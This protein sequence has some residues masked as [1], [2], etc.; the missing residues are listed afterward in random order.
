MEYSP[1]VDRIAGEGAAAWDIHAKA[2]ADQAA[3]EDVIVLSV[4]DPDLDTPA[5]VAESA[6]AA[7]RAG[8]THYTPV[9]GRPELRRAIAERFRAQGGWDAGPENVSVVA[10]AQNGLFSAALMLLQPGDEALILDP[11]YVTYDATVRVAGAEPVRVAPRADGGFRPDPEAIAA[12]VTPKTRALL[13]TTPNNPTGVTLTADELDAIAAIARRHDLWVVS[14][15]VYAGLTFGAPHRSIAAL[16]GMAERTITVSSLSKS[17][18]MTGWRVGWMIGPES[19]VGHARNLSLCMHYGLPGFVQ[20]AAVTAL[21][22]ADSVAGEMRGIYRGR[23][24]RLMAGLRDAPGLTPL[25]PE[26]GMFLMVDIRATGLS[27]TDFAWALYRETGVSAL[28]AAPFGTSGQ[29][30]VRLSFTKSD[31][32]LSEAA[33]RIV[34]FCRGLAAAPAPPAAREAGHG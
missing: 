24:D 22:H 11:C 7:L 9:S 25:E 18:A 33:R 6:V 19:L 34:S 14:D 21:A 16:P 23:R 5:P 26:A 32:E 30:Y 29:G 20:A 31:A 1:L 15:E 10:G 12:A 27:G 2:L 28:D 17:H 4:G 13:V 8:D 3:G